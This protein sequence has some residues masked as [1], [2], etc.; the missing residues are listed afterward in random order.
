MWGG[1]GGLAPP[2][3]LRFLRLCIQP[4]A[5]KERTQEGGIRRKEEWT[6]GE[7][8]EGGE[9][10]VWGGREGIACI[11]RERREGCEE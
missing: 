5:I 11:E 2:P 1:G 9:G 10:T 4:K 6:V 3:P 7:G 8:K